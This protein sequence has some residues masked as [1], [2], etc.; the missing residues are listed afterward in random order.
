M[1]AYL[2]FFVPLALLTACNGKSGT[3]F[4][5]KPPAQTMSIAEREA[6]IEARR[7]ELALVDTALCT[8]SGVKLS[9]FTPLPNDTLYISQQMNHAL[10]L[11]ALSIASQNGIAG[12]GGDPNF[13]LAVDLATCQ[14]QLTA[15]TPQKVMLTYEAALYVGNVSTG[16]V[17]GT[18]TLRLTGIGH[19]AQSAALEAAKSLK[20]NKEIQQM[21]ASATER[22]V[23]YYQTHASTIKLQVESL[24]AKGDYDRAFLVLRA[25][26]QEATA[27]HK[28]AQVQLPKVAHKLYQD[29]VRIQQLEAQIKENNAAHAA[30]LEQLRHEKEKQALEMAAQYER[31]CAS[32]SYSYA[33][34]EM[35][36][37][38]S[39]EDA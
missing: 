19:N 21:L 22:I 30:E 11:R 3:K 17:F 8:G 35:R 37:K 5:P 2:S 25:V 27:L 9:I 15:T 36:K 29:D 26:P 28:Y 10:A 12:I 23:T 1:K 13:V 38:I 20:T 32:E 34:T 39:L 24:I 18:T 4:E 7:A 33:S 6:A 16:D 31:K 14:K